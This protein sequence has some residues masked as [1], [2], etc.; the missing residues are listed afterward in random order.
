[1]RQALESFVGER[2]RSELPVLLQLMCQFMFMP[3]SERIVEGEHAK[4]AKG[5]VHRRV[6]GAYVS[7]HLRLPEVCAMLKSSDAA[8]SST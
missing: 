1:M 2:S 6:S 8:G 4:I 3:T 5:T 7:L